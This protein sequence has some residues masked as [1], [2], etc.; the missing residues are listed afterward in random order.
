MPSTVIASASY[1][2]PNSRLIITFVT[3]KVYAYKNVPEEIYRAMMTSGSK[4]VYFNDH[5][6]NHYEFEKLKG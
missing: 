5:I 3:G 1:E 4:G 6:R 2:A